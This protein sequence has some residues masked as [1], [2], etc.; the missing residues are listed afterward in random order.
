MSNPFIKRQVLD[1]AI[2]WGLIV[3]M[4][5]IGVIIGCNGTT[6]DEPLPLGKPTY[7]TLSVSVFSPNCLAC[8]G[9]G[10]RDLST[11]GAVMRFVVPGKPDL[12]PLYTLVESHRMPPGKPLN[13]DR[14][15]EIRSW[16][17]DGASES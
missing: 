3:A 9:P 7:Q 15:E 17:A 16:I 13:D 11:Y 5:V 14:I 2:L 6:I 1:G 12:S 10:P 4:V 8:H